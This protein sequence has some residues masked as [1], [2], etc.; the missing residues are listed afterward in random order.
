MAIR[1]VSYCAWVARSPTTAS[2]GSMGITRPM[3]KVMAKSPRKVRKRVTT[4]PAGPARSRPRRRLRALGAGGTAMD[5]CSIATENPFGTKASTRMVH[6]VHGRQKLHISLPPYKK[7][8]LY[9]KNFGEVELSQAMA[10]Q[11][12]GYPRVG[13]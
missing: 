1:A 11:A 12:E 10:K 7:L 5:C 3:K 9:Q 8:C 13:S 6:T 2:T 4:K